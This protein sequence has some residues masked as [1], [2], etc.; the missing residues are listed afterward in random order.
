MENY[1]RIVTPVY[2]AEKWI[3]KNIESVNKQRNKNYEHIVVDDGSTDKTVEIVK[4]LQLR[5]PRITL[6][7]KSKRSGVM[8]SHLQ[9]LFTTQKPVNE[10][11]IVVQ[12]DGDDWFKGVKVLDKLNELYQNPDVWATYGNYSTTDNSPSVC[13]PFNFD[14][15]P[16]EYIKRGWIFSHVRTFRFSVLK[17]IKRESLYLKGP[18]PIL[19][20][21][22]AD[23]ALF[24]P[25][26]ELAGYDRVRFVTEPLCVHNRDNP[27][28]EDK[29]S[30]QTQAYCFSSIAAG[31]LYERIQ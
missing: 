17:H 15:P 19:Y 31:K 10:K 29:V 26:L 22:A 27:L 30:L 4:K 11:C 9:G 18:N 24:C 6:I 14:I 20:P 1:F 13:S 16:R 12:L 21:A 3:E 7:A 23:V 28:N 2:N 25:I 8:D 5:Y